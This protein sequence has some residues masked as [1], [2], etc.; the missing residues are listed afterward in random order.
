MDMRRSGPQ[1]SHEIEGVTT[2]EVSRGD[3][4][5]LFSSSSIYIFFFSSHYFILLYQRCLFCKADSKGEHLCWSAGGR[6]NRRPIRCAKGGQHTLFVCQKRLFEFCLFFNLIFAALPLHLSLATLSRGGTPFWKASS[7]PQSGRN[8]QIISNANINRSPREVAP[9]AA[10]RSVLPS[11]RPKTYKDHIT[12]TSDTVF[13][14]NLELRLPLTMFGFLP[15]LTAS[16]F[17]ED[18]GNSIAMCC[19]SVSTRPR[20][21][22]HLAPYVLHVLHAYAYA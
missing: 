13:N 20:L 4:S 1:K 22:S 5:L 15:F 2:N 14:D 8:N 17:I 10:S 3:Q 18:A 19:S 6:L 11:F 12:D 21:L 9:A 7:D 16:F